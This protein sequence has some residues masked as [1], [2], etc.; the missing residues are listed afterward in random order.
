V[1]SSRPIGIF[2]SGVGGLTVLRQL[3]AHAPAERM[4]YLGDTARLPYGTKSKETIVRYSLHNAAFLQRQEAKLLVVACNT[5]SS[6][7]LEELQR[8]V[9]VP[10]VGVILPG[11]KKAAGCSR[12]G[13]VGVIGTP[14]TVRSGA[15]ET[16]IRGCARD[17]EVVSVACPLFVALAEE[18]WLDDDITV[19]VARRYLEPLRAAGIDVLV[20]GC[21]HYPLLKPVLAEVMGKDVR[22]VDSAEEVAIE[23]ER[24][25]KELGLQTPSPAG[26]GPLP[27][28]IY[29]TDRS[30]HFLELCERILAF[31]PGEVEYVDLG[32]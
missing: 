30:P 17:I 7:A 13:K 32:R 10:V 1:P 19:R 11:A 26:Q 23:V 21:T 9:R 5:A 12:S 20:L 28:E 22:L 14:A 18:G 24:T 31:P 25:L 2:D 27:P 15:Y 3:C 6:L 4:I 29:L 8:E 16:A